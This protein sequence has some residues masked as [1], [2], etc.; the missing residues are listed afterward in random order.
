MPRHEEQEIRPI[1]I[2]LIMVC[3][4]M[5]MGCRT[6]TPNENRDLDDWKRDRH[7]ELFNSGHHCLLYEM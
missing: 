3:I 2:F 4:V 5:F 6:L 1:I 7:F